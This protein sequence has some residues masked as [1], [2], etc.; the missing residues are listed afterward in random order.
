MA[1]R[2]M[3]FLLSVTLI[4]AIFVT[5]AS[6]Q[7]TAITSDAFEGIEAYAYDTDD[8]LSS[9]EKAGILKDYVE[10]PHPFTHFI[11]AYY[12]KRLFLTERFFGANYLKDLSLPNRM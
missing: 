1:M 6:S 3:Q 12:V 8:V 4:V 2:I 7:L 5:T 10:L 9:H 11:S